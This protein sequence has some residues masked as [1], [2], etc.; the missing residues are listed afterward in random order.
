MRATET[1]L[2]SRWWWCGGWRTERADNAPCNGDNGGRDWRRTQGRQTLLLAVTKLAMMDE[3]DRARM[4][5]FRLSLLLL[6]RGMYGRI[7]DCGQWLA[8]LFFPT[9]P[10]NLPSGLGTCWLGGEIALQWQLAPR[11][12]AKSCLSTVVIS[13]GS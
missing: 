12:T 6:P 7:Q 4:R 2:V 11:R 9:R 1:R 8:A 5:I 3:H 13:D 10:L